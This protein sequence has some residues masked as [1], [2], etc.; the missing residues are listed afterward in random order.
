[1]STVLFAHDGYVYLTSEG[2]YSDTYDDKIVSRYLDIAGNVKFMVR[3]RDSF[4]GRGK[5]NRITIENFQVV[6]IDNFKSLRGILDYRAIAD[7]VSAE[8]KVADYVVARLPSDLGFL[9]AHYAR[10]YGKK[11]MVEIVGCPWDSL[12]NHSLVGKVL[13]PCYFSSKSKLQEMHHTRFMLRSDSYKVAIRVGECHS[14][15]L[16]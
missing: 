12:R 14:V 11:Y 10:R 16:M 15:A 8:V 13:A 3:V 6:G 2:I 5:L 1:M 7:R 4:N 9:A